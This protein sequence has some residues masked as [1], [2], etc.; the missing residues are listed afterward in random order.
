MMVYRTNLVRFVPRRLS[1]SNITV[2]CLVEGTDGSLHDA[3]A[4]EGPLD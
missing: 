3:S 2:K 4:S 1:I